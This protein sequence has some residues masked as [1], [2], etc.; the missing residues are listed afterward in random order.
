MVHGRAA[1]WYLHHEY[2]VIYV[3]SGTVY[4]LVGM[5]ATVVLN[6]IVG[7]LWPVACIW[8]GPMVVRRLTGWEDPLP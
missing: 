2:A 8:L 6:W 5:R 1:R 7:P 4:V 3:V